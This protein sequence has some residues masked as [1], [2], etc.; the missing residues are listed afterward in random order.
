LH[1]KLPDLRN[2]LRRGCK[3]QGCEL[4]PETARF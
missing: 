2:A 4:S 3:K 1:R